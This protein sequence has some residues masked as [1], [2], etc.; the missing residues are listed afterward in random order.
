MMLKC[1]HNELPKLEQAI[2]AAFFSTFQSTIS[3]NGDISGFRS[4]ES[5]NEITGCIFVSQ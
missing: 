3:S 5:E 4:K 2:K 1:A